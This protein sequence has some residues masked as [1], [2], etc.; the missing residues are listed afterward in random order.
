MVFYN[1]WPHGLVE[2]SWDKIYFPSQSGVY[3]QGIYPWITDMTTNG[4]NFCIRDTV[5]WKVLFYCPVSGS[6]IGS[7]SVNFVNF[8]VCVI[9]VILESVWMQLH[10]LFVSQGLEY[11]MQG[12]RFVEAR[13]DF[14]VNRIPE[15]HRISAYWISGVRARFGCDSIEFQLD[16]CVNGGPEYWIS[17]GGVAFRWGQDRFLR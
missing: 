14:P 13:A 12:W 2:G 16:S 11:Q 5:G 10:E 6:V 1:L 7:V 15:Y 3:L 17:D 4:G 8:P 9:S